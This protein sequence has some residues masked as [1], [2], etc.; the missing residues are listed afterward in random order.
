MECAYGNCK[1]NVNERFGYAWCWTEGALMT[2][3]ESHFELFLENSDCG[4]V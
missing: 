4:G 1:F 3:R 2:A